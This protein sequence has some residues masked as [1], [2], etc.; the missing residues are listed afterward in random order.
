MWGMLGETEVH[1]VNPPKLVEKKAKRGAKKLKKP[2][3]TAMRA[4]CTKFVQDHTQ[5]RW[6]GMFGSSGCLT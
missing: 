3:H 2:S 4:L 6:V 5:G 1:G